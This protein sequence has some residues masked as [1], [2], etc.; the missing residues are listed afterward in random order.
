M[1]IFPL[2]AIAKTIVVILS[3]LLILPFLFGLA[4]ATPVYNN[5]ENRVASTG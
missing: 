4:K 1:R 5:F 2:T 3:I